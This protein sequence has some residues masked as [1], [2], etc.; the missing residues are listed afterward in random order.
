[1]PEPGESNNPNP[2]T[3]SINPPKKMLK[4]LDWFTTVAWKK[5]RT[6]A[7]VILVAGMIIMARVVIYQQR[8]IVELEE[9]NT[10]LQS[11]CNRRMDSLTIGYLAREEKLSAET[12]QTLNLMIQDY[13]A[14][15]EEQREINRKVSSSIMETTE[16]IKNNKTKL[17]QLRNVN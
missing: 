17:K 11:D 8:R 16:T 13:K 15:L 12:K 1:M 2:I 10:S 7:F 6:L 14:Q 5:P 9:K 4:L 3:N